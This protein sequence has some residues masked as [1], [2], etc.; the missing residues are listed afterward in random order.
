MTRTGALMLVLAVALSK[1]GYAKRPVRTPCP[2]GRFRVRD[3]TP[4]ASAGLADPDAVVLETPVA[5][6]VGIGQ[7]CASTPARI[8]ATKKGTLVRA[9]WAKCGAVGRVS[10]SAVIAPG[11]TDMTG[12]VRVKG[13]A[14]TLAAVRAQCG[15]G[16]IDPGNGEHCEVDVGGCD[17]GFTCDRCDCVAPTST[18]TTTVPVALFDAANVWSTDGTPPPAD[19]IMVTPEEYEAAAQ[20][21]YVSLVKDR[22][23]ADAAA[24]AARIQADRDLVDKTRAQRPE[25]REIHL[26]PPA[27]AQ[28][29]GDNWQVQVQTANGPQPVVLQGENSLYSDVAA[30][31]RRFPTRANQES[32]YRTLYPRLPGDRRDGLP[33]PDQLGDIS[34]EGLNALRAEV[35]R[36]LDE[37]LPNASPPEDFAPSALARAR[38]RDAS[39]DCSHYNFGVYKKLT[40]PLKP[41]TSPVRSQGNRGSC[42]AHGIAAGLETFLSKFDGLPFLDLSEQELYAFAK[43]RWFHDDYDDGL[44]CENT[45]EEMQE[46]GFPLHAEGA[47]MYN[48]SWDRVADDDSETYTHSCDNYTQT[49]SNTAHQLGKYCTSQN[50]HTYCATQTEIEHTGQAGASYVLTDIAELWNHLEPE[51]SLQTV[52]SYLASGFPVVVAATLD[53]CFEKQPYPEQAYV[54]Y[55]DQDDVGSHAI[56]VT[57]YKT[58]QQIATLPH[59]P[60][61]GN[62]PPQGYGKHFY[63]IK[64]S[65]GCDWGDGGY[66]YA[67]ADWMVSHVQT[68]TAI[69]GMS[70]GGLPSV[71][72]SADKSLVSTGGTVTLTADANAAVA[73]VDFYEGFTKIG[74]ADAPPFTHAITYGAAD[75][76]SHYYF[77]LAFDAGNNQTQS[78]VIEVK[79][80]IDTKPPTCS[81]S[82]SSPTVAVPP[83]TVT[84]TAAAS[85]DKGVAK[86]EFF[87]RKLIPILNGYFET[88]I[89]LGEDTTKPYTLSFNY[90]GGD[91]GTHSYRAIASDA[92]GNKGKSNVVG[93]TVLG[94]L[95]PII[96]T[97]TATPSVLPPGGGQTLLA[98]TT[99]GA[100]TLS[101]DQ[102]VGTVTGTT[103][104]MVAVTQ[105]THYTLTA[106]NPQGV[107]TAQA[108]VFV[109]P[110]T[111]STLVGTTSTSSS[112]STTST[113]TTST[114]SSTTTTSTST[115]T[116]ETSTSSSTTSSTVTTTSETS[117]SSTSTTTSPA[118]TST[119]STTP[120][121]LPTCSVLGAACGSCGNPTGNCQPACSHGCGLVCA[122]SSG[123]GSCNSDGD[124][125]AGEICAGNPAATCLGLPGMCSTT[126]PGVCSHPCP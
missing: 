121:T 17:A 34:V 68:A 36:R 35:T 20:G 110:A 83:G 1:D 11:C 8:K 37:V 56:L 19:A 9:R 98:W 30:A 45:L 85:D 48:P 52:R 51:N 65:W 101:I 81:L 91:V 74:S 114:S 86:V 24:E 84:F 71:S 39:P 4:L 53:E 103:S 90:G 87:Q 32:I 93:V 104:K 94:L 5:S 63:V 102:G 122:L 38:P 54:L 26:T 80:D 118:S 55:P 22:L 67:Y 42:V 7:G 50:G 88:L 77:V 46:R 49:C 116:T 29:I 123:H 96:S 64:N 97:F 73:R 59:D 43:G 82:V 60:F 28:P 25:L 16:V 108:L 72:I 47:W 3:Q 99:L 13:K 41:Y 27:D 44:P 92:A 112:T 117:T 119:T 58:G 105:T 126:G 79:V 89:K 31:L 18:T 57:G 10:L 66:V 107:T 33:T 2:G 111:T 15:D 12:T 113:S 62:D 100:N 75:N 40:W 106:T 125:P 14:R 115:S 69:V 70:T 61:T 76:G 21:G 124:C 109:A 78:D 6:Q 95:K 120:S 23:A